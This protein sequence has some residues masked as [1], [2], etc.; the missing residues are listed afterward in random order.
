M[1]AHEGLGGPFGWA[2]VGLLLLMVIVAV[3]TGFSNLFYFAIVLVPVLF[4]VMI[5]LCMGKVEDEA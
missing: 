2:S 5:A 3:T 1:N 4:Y